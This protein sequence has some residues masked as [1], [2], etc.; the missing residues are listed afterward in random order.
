MGEVARRYRYLNHPGEVGVIASVTQP[1]CGDCNRARL[2]ADGRLI[3][4]LFAADGRDL[5]GPMKAGDS[6]DKLRALIGET[7]S[8]RTDRYSE[9]RAALASDPRERVRLE[10]YQIGG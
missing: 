4:C 5:S 3:T 9:Q 2:S 1:F 10:M 7:W 8:H 6:D